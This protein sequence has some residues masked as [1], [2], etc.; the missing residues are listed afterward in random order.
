MNVRV[1]HRRLLAESARQRCEGLRVGVAG[2]RQRVVEARDEGE[3]LRAQR[4][5]RDAVERGEE[6]HS[7]EKLRPTLP[8]A[9]R[10]DVAQSRSRIRKKR[11]DVDVAVVAAALGE[12]AQDDVLQKSFLGRNSRGRRSIVVAV[13]DV[14][15][16]VVVRT[17]TSRLRVL[18]QLL[19]NQP[20]ETDSRSWRRRQGA[21]R[22][23]VFCAGR[24]TREKFPQRGVA[25]VVRCDVRVRAML[26]LLLMLLVA[27][28]DRR[29]RKNLAA[30]LLVRCCCCCCQ[31]NACFCLLRS[32]R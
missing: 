22:F 12:V 16:V 21:A 30:L 15:V 29:L 24:K 17:G 11:R 2:R 8:R 9:V 7:F 31:K 10:P 26:L 28:V 4:P 13:A 23:C 6:S 32:C 18:L 1:Q 25:R 19:L 27:R 20:V 5:V 14:V 3:R